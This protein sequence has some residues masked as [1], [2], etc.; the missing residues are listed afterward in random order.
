MIWYDNAN[1]DMKMCDLSRGWTGLQQ[2][3]RK[4]G[5]EQLVNQLL[6]YLVTFFTEILIWH[7]LLSS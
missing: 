5:W 4:F 2:M 7:F 6:T 1:E 3:E